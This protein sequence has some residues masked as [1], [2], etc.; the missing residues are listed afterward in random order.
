MQSKARNE[1]KVQLS[2]LCG[3]QQIIQPTT[4]LPSDRKKDVV[5]STKQMKLQ[6][7]HQGF[8]LVPDETAT[9]SMTSL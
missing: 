2:R 7:V 4:L 8:N 9:Q 3:K 1:R 5:S 6:F